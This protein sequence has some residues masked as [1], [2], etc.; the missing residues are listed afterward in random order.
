MYIGY[1]STFLNVIKAKLN[2]V[3]LLY[4]CIID[5]FHILSTFRLFYKLVPL[6]LK[7]R[8]KNQQKTSVA[9]VCVFF[10]NNVLGVL[11]D[12]PIP[13]RKTDIKECNR[14]MLVHY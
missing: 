9:A 5:S 4:C 2:E 8:K 1:I 12:N 6:F 10:L 14:G 7:E 13:E 3:S 11:A